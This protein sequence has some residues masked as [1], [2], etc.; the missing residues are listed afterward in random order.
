MNVESPALRRAGRWCYASAVEWEDVV[1]LE[2]AKQ[3]LKA[4]EEE[5]AD[6]PFVEFHA[7]ERQG[8][9]LHVDVTARL[10]KSAHKEGVW[11][12]REMLATLKNAAYGFDKGRAWSIGGRDS[13]FRIDRTSVR[14]T[15]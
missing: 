5:L 14:P 8:R 11:R 4:V 9:T 1:E 3:R 10:R 7:F 12:S 2:E 13:L 15:R 6:A